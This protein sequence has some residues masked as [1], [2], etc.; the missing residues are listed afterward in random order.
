MTELVCCMPVSAK[1]QVQ[2]VHVHI[3]KIR[4]YFR[5]FYD[6]VQCAGCMCPQSTLVQKVHVQCRMYMYTVLLT[7]RCSACPL[8]CV[9]HNAWWDG[10]V[11]SA[12]RFLPHVPWGRWCAGDMCSQ[13]TP[14]Q[15]RQLPVKY[16]NWFSYIRSHY[17]LHIISKTIITVNLLQTFFR[18]KSNLY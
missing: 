5:T 13:R 17:T 9:R 18:R 14:R 16:Q 4:G 3:M 8:I 7:D 12:E 6:G 15:R 2:R 10:S 11:R 1:Y